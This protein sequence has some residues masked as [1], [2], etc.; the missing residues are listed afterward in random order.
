MRRCLTLVLGFGNQTSRRPVRLGMKV[1]TLVLVG[2]MVI[3]L[4][5]CTS[6]SSTTSQRVQPSPTIA[7][8]EA[9]A[10]SSPQPLFGLGERLTCLPENRTVG[11]YDRSKP[12]PGTSVSD[13]LG[14][15][16]A[17]ARVVARRGGDTLTVEIV[18]GDQVT[19]VRVLTRWPK[20]R[21]G[22]SVEF[23][24]DCR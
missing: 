15:E 12:L 17:R 16:A 18:D 19:G 10:S 7:A 24:A 1:F 3:A 21:G 23:F 2:A 13:A 11:A 8:S 20:R 6:P 4:A 14:K 22:W 5:A 9:S